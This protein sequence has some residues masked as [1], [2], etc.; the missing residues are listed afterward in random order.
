VVNAFDPSAVVADIVCGPA[1]PE[2]I[3]AG[4]E[5]SDQIGELLVERVLPGVAAQGR[6]D[7]GRVLLPVREEDP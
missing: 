5:L 2:S 7:A 6:D 3:A 1:V 4:N